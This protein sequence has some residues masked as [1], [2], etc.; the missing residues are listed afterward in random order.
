MIKKILHPGLGRCG[1]TAK[2]LHY[3][4]EICLINNWNFISLAKRKGLAY[5][6]KLLKW[7]KKLQNKKNKTNTSLN[8]IHFNKSIFISNEGFLEFNN[9]W[10]PEF[11]N[12]S[13][14][15]LCKKF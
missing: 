2:Q 14:K 3:W 13:I 11:Y 6:L 4:P 1:T 10:D 9:S 15:Y 12:K 7:L 5:D 8:K